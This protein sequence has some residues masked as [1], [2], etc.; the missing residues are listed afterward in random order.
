M[1]RLMKGRASFVIAY[2]LNTIRNVDQ[3]LVLEDGRIIEKGAH[4]TLLAGKGF[5]YS[6]YHSQLKEEIV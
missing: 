5:Y 6:L 1:Q 3:I 2:R 4:D